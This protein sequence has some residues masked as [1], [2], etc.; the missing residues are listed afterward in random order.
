MS[1]LYI[2]LVSYLNPHDIPIFTRKF[3]VFDL[4]C[5]V[6]VCVRGPIVSI[7]SLVRCTPQQI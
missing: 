2:P 4:K 1:S 7:A 6:C 3:V 5:G